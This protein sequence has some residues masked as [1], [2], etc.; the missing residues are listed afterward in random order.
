MQRA[1]TDAGHRVY[2]ASTAKEA[3]AL[4]YLI[5][6]PVRLT[7]VDLRLPDRPGIELA[8][9][10]VDEGL[11]RS[12]LLTSGDDSLIQEAEIERAAGRWAYLAKPFTPRRL[13]WVVQAILEAPTSYDS[14]QADRRT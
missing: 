13:V 6:R 5:N 2:E 14:S 3:L 11:S 8:T 7:I 1:L 9:D 12:I 10:I 4:L